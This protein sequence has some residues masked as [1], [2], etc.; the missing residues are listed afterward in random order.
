MGLST[1]AFCRLR[2]L[3]EVNRKELESDYTAK[4]QILGFIDHSH[5][6]TS[7]LFKDVIVRDGLANH[8][9]KMLR[10]QNRQ[11]NELPRYPFAS[12]GVLRRNGGLPSRKSCSEYVG[13]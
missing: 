8:R 1:K 3:G 2:I 13:I 9:R 6:T 11:V 12:R 10:L 4:G 7:Q 5:P